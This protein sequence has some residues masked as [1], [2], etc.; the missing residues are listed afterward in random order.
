MTNKTSKSIFLLLLCSCIGNAGSLDWKDT[1][2][3]WNKFDADKIIAE[4]REQ[5]N[6][7]GGFSLGSNVTSAVSSAN[8]LLNQASS[9]GLDKYTGGAIGKAQSMLSMVN[10]ANYQSLIMNTGLQLLGGAD[11]A[12]LGVC[13][14]KTIDFSFP[15]I[16]MPDIKIDPCVKFDVGSGGTDVC[17]LAPD[18]PGYKKKSQNILEIDQR[19]VRLFC[20]GWDDMV[21]IEKTTPT[22]K[23]IENDSSKSISETSKLAENTN[24]VE[25]IKRTQVAN[26]GRMS[27]FKY[28]T[29]LKDS[30]G[31][32]IKD[33]YGQAKTKI[34]Q[35]FKGFESQDT[36]DKKQAYKFVKKVLQKEAAEGKTADQIEETK[37]ITLAHVDKANIA[38]KTEH[39][40][41]LARTE[42]IDKL[43]F[44]EKKIFSTKDEVLLFRTKVM[45][46]EFGGEK[47][48]SDGSVRAGQIKAE[49]D[50]LMAQYKEQV[51]KWLKIKEA[52]YFEYEKKG[53][54][55]PTA[56][57]IENI[58]KNLP[59]NERHIKRASLVYQVDKEMN[60]D[61][62]HVSLLRIKAN[63]MV[64]EFER[65]L[66]I[67]IIANKKFDLDSAMKAAG[68]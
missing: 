10:D 31:N 4:K 66:D 28:E 37:K 38:Y 54:D 3:N 47:Y 18:I 9:Y 21:E 15:S 39:E 55:A 52:Y 11:S 2:K 64:D 40:Y 43:N 7:I 58:T 48:I 45:G 67:E 30:S 44:I 61:A 16:S 26:V 63:E 50:N 42:A 25:K 56:Y 68:L 24:V 1:A 14:E 8:N 51:D 27:E 12:L 62:Q 33:Q 65:K 23:I 35:P 53:I 36:K 22:Q 32:V 59:E 41:E 20:N 19:N 49:K 5:Y 60:M 57:Y 46:Y 13:Y 6:P 34:V 29:K 17:S